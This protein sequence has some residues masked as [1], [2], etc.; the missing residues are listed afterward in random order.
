MRSA[1]APAET[2]AR[3][4]T[5][6]FLELTG[7]LGL[8]PRHPAAAAILTLVTDDAPPPHGAVEVDDLGSRLRISARLATSR[9]VPSAVVVERAVGA[10]REVMGSRAFA[11]ELELEL[12][13]IE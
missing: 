11:L 7:V 2:A 13:V 10:V 6:R 8:F 3:E 5:G 1:S 12:A 9:A 4:L